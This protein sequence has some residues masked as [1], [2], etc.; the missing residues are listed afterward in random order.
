MSELKRVIPGMGIGT[1]EDRLKL[2]SERLDEVHTAA[3][4]LA[5][6]DPVKYALLSLS[7]AV[8]GLQFIVR[9][10][11]DHRGQEFNDHLRDLVRGLE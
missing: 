9:N 2:V 4:L 8:S 6:G 5:P 10:D 1:I 3:G 7:K 11:L